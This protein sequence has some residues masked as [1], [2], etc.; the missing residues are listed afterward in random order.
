[1]SA[2]SFVNPKRDITGS[3]GRGRGAG[4]RELNSLSETLQN[5][6]ACASLPSPKSAGHTIWNRQFLKS[7]QVHL[8]PGSRDGLTG[9]FSAFKPLPRVTGHVFV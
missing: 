2:D 7:I 5:T 3:G 1:M 9:Y 4:D 8:P 6:D